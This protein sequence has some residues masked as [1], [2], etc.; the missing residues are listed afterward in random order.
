MFFALATRSNHTSPCVD[1]GTNLAW[2]A[3]ATDYFADDRIV[4]GIVDMGA[5]EYYA[6]VTATPIDYSAR[7]IGV[8][9]VMK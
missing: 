1:T 4:N 3:S 2:M 6:E 8:W 7:A 9:R 5:A